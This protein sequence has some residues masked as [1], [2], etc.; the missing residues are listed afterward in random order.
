MVKNTEALWIRA[1]S[2]STEVFFPER[3]FK[4]IKDNGESS[5]GVVLSTS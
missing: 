5:G 4:W 2:G 3:H 1:N